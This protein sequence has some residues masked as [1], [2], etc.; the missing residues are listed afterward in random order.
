MCL[1]INRAILAQASLLFSR[2]C[3]HPALLKAPLCFSASP[4]LSVDP[5]VTLLYTAHITTVHPYPPSPHTH[6]DKHKHAHHPSH[7]PN[8]FLSRF[9]PPLASQVMTFSCVE[10][11][12][13]L[14]RSP[15]PRTLSLTNQK[16][17]HVGAYF[18]RV[19]VGRQATSKDTFSSPSRS[20]LPLPQHAGHP[21]TKAPSI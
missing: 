18:S 6:T 3:S 10:F 16:G 4:H 15:S 14:H 20:I 8:R 17:V 12:A 19:A 9:V 2:A 1:Q 11:T 13:H 5:G 21:L 7:Y